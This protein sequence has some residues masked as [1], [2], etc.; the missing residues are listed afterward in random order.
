[1]CCSLGTKQSLLSAMVIT[2]GSN[3]LFNNCQV[4]FFFRFLTLIK[5]FKKL[6]SLAYFIVSE[7]NSVVTDFE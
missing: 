3:P 4:M 6:F 7:P 5:P 2:N 1:M